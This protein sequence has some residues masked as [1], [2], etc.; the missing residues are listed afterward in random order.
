M[1]E[2]YIEALE[3]LPLP[4]EDDRLEAAHT[5]ALAAALAAFDKDSFGVAESPDLNVRPLHLWLPQHSHAYLLNALFVEC[6]TVV[7]LPKGSHP[8]GRSV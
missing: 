6:W 1:K 7:K 2:E 8:R 4:A 3:A 5:R